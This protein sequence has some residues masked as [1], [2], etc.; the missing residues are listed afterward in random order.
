MRAGAGCGGLSVTAVVP[1]RRSWLW[2]QGLACGAALSIATAPVI[3]LVILLAPGLIVYAIEGGERKPLSS[4]MLLLGLATS[5]MPL[6]VLWDTGHSMEACVALLS[7]PTRVGFSWL[8]A[9]TGWLMEEGAQIISRQYSDLATRRRIAQ[10]R[11]ERAELVEE[12]GPLVQL[13]PLPPQP[14]IR[15]R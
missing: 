13:P 4:S 1:R 10:L 9:G 7:D 6:R 5:F 2:L 15:R 14:V 11:A 3:L 8:A 12:W